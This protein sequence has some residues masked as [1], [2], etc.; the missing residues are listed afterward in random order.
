MLNRVPSFRVPV[1]HLFQKLLKVLSPSQKVLEISHCN[2][3]LLLPKRFMQAVS[4]E[5]HCLASWSF[6]SQAVA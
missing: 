3:S 1:S 6:T 5:T 2:S 4:N